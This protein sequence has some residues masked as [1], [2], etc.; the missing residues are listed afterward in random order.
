MGTVGFEP[1]TSWSSAM[2]SP[3]LNYVP[4]INKKHNLYNDYGGTVQKVSDGRPA[5]SCFS[6]CHCSL[7]HSRNRLTHDRAGKQVE[8]HHH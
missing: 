1:T 2:C 8:Q 6:G 5:A 4:K 3:S 7:S